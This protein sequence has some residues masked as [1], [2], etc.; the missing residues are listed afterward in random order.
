MAIFNSYVKLPEGIRRFTPFYSQDF[1]WLSIFIEDTVDLTFIEPTFFPIGFFVRL[2]PGLWP[3]RT[4]PAFG[5]STKGT[6]M[7]EGGQKCFG[8]TRAQN[9][10]FTMKNAGLSTCCF[11]RLGQYTTACLTLIFIHHNTN[12]RGETVTS[13]RNSVVAGVDYVHGEYRG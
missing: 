9:G 1:L 5:R 2:G 4:G 13:F 8:P 3:T 12:C 10:G 6:A 11:N 7:S